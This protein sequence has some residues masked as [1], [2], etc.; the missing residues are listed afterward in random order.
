[1]S[2]I[3][4]PFWPRVPRPSLQSTI[5]PYTI[6]RGGLSVSR[7]EVLIIVAIALPA[8]QITKGVVTG[9]VSL[10]R[11]KSRRGVAMATAV[12]DGVKRHCLGSQSHWRFMAN[13]IHLALI[14]PA[15]S[16]LVTIA[17]SI[18]VARDAR[19]TA[20]DC[21]KQVGRPTRF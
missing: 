7:A 9:S 18:T 16:V 17:Q 11:G 3:F 21:P 12:S 20:S 10:L 6:G 14:S 8:K 4:L 13:E 5:F 15:I 1:M 19:Q 2:Y